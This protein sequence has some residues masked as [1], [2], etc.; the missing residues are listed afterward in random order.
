MEGLKTLKGNFGDVDSQGA[1]LLTGKTRIKEPGALF[2][3]FHPAA[4]LI[5]DNAEENGTDGN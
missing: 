5:L 4:E 2:I 3:F 1:F